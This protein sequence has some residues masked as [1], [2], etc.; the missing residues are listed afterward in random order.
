MLKGGSISTSIWDRNCEQ[1]QDRDGERGK[2]LSFLSSAHR[3]I[4]ALC[5]CAGA[6]SDAFLI[7]VVEYLTEMEGSQVN[8]IVN[9]LQRF[10]WVDY[11]VFVLML[12][13][14]LRNP[15]GSPTEMYLYGQYAFIMGGIIL[16]SLVMTQVYLP[17]FH[18]LKITSNYEGGLQAVVWTDV[19]QIS[20]MFGAMALVAIK[21]TIDVG[22]FSEVWRLNLEGHRIETPNWD[23]SPL[24]R[25]TVWSLVIGGLVYWLQANAV[26]QTMVQRVSLCCRERYDIAA[27]DD[28]GSYH[29]GPQLGVFTMGIPHA[30]GS[31]CFYFKL[32]GLTLLSLQWFS[33]GWSCFAKGKWTTGTLIRKSENCYFMVISWCTC[34]RSDWIGGN[35]LVVFVSPARPCSWT[36]T[37]FTQTSFGGWLHIITPSLMLLHLL[38]ILMSSNPYQVVRLPSKMSYH[39]TTSSSSQAVNPLLRVSY[40]WYTLAGA[41]VAICVGAAV[42]GARRMRKGDAYVP[43]PPALLAP[44]ASSLSRAPASR[45]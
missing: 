36:H 42:S 10:T 41:A 25:H 16:M 39:A 30:V 8:E 40:M 12:A 23:P 19:I 29:Y 31:V 21:G 44:I 37:A 33:V 13:F 22:G 5:L 2:R 28:V 34:R 20:A 14:R 43:P 45:R 17:V 4:P 6:L 35:E 15:L 18:D 26:N 27:D 32:R 3:V 1:N 7:S 11:V 24:T 9:N 38:Q